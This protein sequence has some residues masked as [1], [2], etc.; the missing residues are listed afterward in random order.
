MR[1]Y[2]T[3]GGHIESVE[4]LIGHSDEEAT[5]ISHKL[6]LKRKNTFDGFELW[7]RARVITRFPKPIDPKP[8]TPQLFPR[9]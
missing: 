1:C 5:D 7:D 4:E 2:F 6:F 3:R 8:E 9:A